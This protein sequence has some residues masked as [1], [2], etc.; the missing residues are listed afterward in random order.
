MRRRRATFLGVAML[1][2][3]LSACRHQDIDA[4]MTITLTSPA[5]QAGQPIP[6][7]FTC[8]GA[9]ISPAL[10]WDTLPP[11]TKSIVLTMIDQSS[12][13]AGYVHWLLY[14]LP[15][16]T[17]QLPENLPRQET[18]SSGA[19][20]GRNGNGSPGYTGPCPPGKSPHHYL[21]TLYALNNTLTVPAGA[22]KG[23]MMN[24]MQGHVLAT[25]K[26]LGTYQ[27]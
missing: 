13:F 7:Q 11:G 17:N 22:S 10:S 21:F 3:W 27:P 1:F 25:G 15:A 16:Q 14:N 12:L 23:E 20:Q 5:F 24:A 18:L 8:H 4:P 9:N 6:A 2:A 19:M 26:L